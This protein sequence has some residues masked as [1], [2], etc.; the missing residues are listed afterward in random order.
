MKEVYFDTNVYTHLA[1]SIQRKNFVAIDKLRKA[2]LSDQ[3]RILSSFTV[4]E[5]T[6]GALIEYPEEAFQRLRLIKKLA[7]RKKLIKLHFEIL[8]D[9]IISYATHQPF[10]SHFMAPFPRLKNLFV[11]NDLSGLIEVAKKTKEYIGG[12]RDEMRNSFSEHIAPLAQA[13]IANREVPTFEKNYQDNAIEFVRLMA[14]PSGKLA[15]CEAR[16]LD[17]LLEVPSINVYVRAQLSLIYANTYQGRLQNQGD[18][19]DMQHVLLAAT[20]AVFIT[21]DN[22]LRKVLKRA[23][24]P[25]LTVLSLQDLLDAPP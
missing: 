13:V 11:G 15:A 23:N 6:A 12:F 21:Q 19:R 16:G 10:K 8:N 7:K 25:F 9:D 20:A 18:S 14:K 24:S 17:G 3:L 4:L 1:Q 2:V 5:E 22:P